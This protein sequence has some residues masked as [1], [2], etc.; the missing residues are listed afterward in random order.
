MRRAVALWLVRA[1]AVLTPR[2]GMDCRDTPGHDGERTD[3][4]RNLSPGPPYPDTH[5]DTLGRDGGAARASRTQPA[6]SR[7]RSPF[8]LRPFT[9]DCRGAAAVEFAL[10]SLAFF[11]LCFA[12]IE[13]GLLLWTQ[14][15]LQSTALQTARCVAVAAP[16]CTGNAPQYAVNAASTWLTPGMLNVSGVSVRTN[17]TCATAPGTAV[18]V[19]LTSTYFAGS[20]AAA[21]FSSPT[22]TATGCY[23]TS[24]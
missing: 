22:L 9:A 2:K 15:A 3:R 10:V 23:P 17:A 14:D 24:P 12:I 4:P 1:G 21:L 18:V 16:A 19:T 7:M 8:R 20:P 13:L 5:G 6:M 11:P